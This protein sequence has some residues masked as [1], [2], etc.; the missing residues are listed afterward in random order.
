[1]NK[2]AFIAIGL[3]FL[4]GFI[5]SIGAVTFLLARF[6]SRKLLKNKSSF[7]K[8]VATTI[9]TPILLI[10]LFYIAISP[11]LLSGRNGGV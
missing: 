1:V 11:L 10:L 7:F 2:Y 9:L 3:F 8:I 5:I 4:S 6:I